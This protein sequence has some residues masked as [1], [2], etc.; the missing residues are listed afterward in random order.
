M[1]DMHG[2][3]INENEQ[4]YIVL[5]CGHARVCGTCVEQLEQRD[6][7]CPMC[8]ARNISFQRVFFS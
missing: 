2:S 3:K 8:R 1:Y 4:Q 5:P 7:A 6:G